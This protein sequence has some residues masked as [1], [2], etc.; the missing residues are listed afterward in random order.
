MEL[1]LSVSWRRTAMRTVTERNDA[2]IN[3]VNVLMGLMLM[4]SPWVRGFATNRTATWVA[5]ISGLVIAAASLTALLQLL[6][7]EERIE[8]EERVNAVAGLFIIGSPWLFGFAEV[9]SATWTYVLIGLVVT[10]LAVV[11]LWR[12]HVGESGEPA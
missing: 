11:E 2:V 5:G 4:S 3:A 7:W 8:W 6:V 10:T 9:T 12:L 1:K